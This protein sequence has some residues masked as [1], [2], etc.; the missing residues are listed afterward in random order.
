VTDLTDP[1]RE[2][3]VAPVKPARTTRH[4]FQYDVL[5]MPTLEDAG[6]DRQPPAHTYAFKVDKLLQAVDGQTLGY[7]WI[8]LVENWHATA[9]TSFG[10][11][12]GVW[13]TSG[14]PKLPFYSRNFQDVKQWVSAV[15]PDQLMPTIKD[16]QQPQTYF[17]KTP[18]GAGEPRRLATRPDAVQSF[19]LDLSPSAAGVWR[20]AS[21]GRRSGGHDSR[22]RPR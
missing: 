1:N 4:L 14:G 12:H 6:F 13:E 20:R 5:R 19:G 11:G 7:T 17:A 16:L 2:K 15:S 9:F 22:S 3:A 18:P 21:S 10:D 8:G